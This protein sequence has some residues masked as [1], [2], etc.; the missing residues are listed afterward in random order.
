MFS[1]LR[2]MGM[3]PTRVATLGVTTLIGAGVSA[4]SAQ[5]AYTVTFVQQGP[6]V[7]ATGKGSFDLTDLIL[8][9]GI[10]SNALVAPSLS[11]VFTGPVTPTGTAADT[12]DGLT[13][14]TAFGSG[15][16]THADSGSGDF[17]GVSFGSAL[18]VPGGYS[19]G[20]PLSDT[21]TYLGQSFASLGMTPGTY[22][23][24]WGSGANADSFTLQIGAAAVPEPASLTLLTVGL[25]G[26]GV[27]RRRRVA[28]KRSV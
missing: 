1:A 4:P 22:V 21:A 6:N 10:S 24:T 11:V 8:S 26:L 5:A 19:S 7:V 28:T 12:Y 23:W 15:G 16:I 18:E 20:N 2:I 9:G 14:P 3:T 25:A 17:V 27:A 13:G